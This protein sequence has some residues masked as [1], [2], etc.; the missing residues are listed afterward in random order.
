MFTVTG[1][2]R[3]VKTFHNNHWTHCTD[4][5]VWVHVPVLFWFHMRKFKNPIFCSVLK[6]EQWILVYS[7]W[8]NESKYGKLNP[9]LWNDWV[10][11]KIVSICGKRQLLSLLPLCYHKWLRSKPPR[12]PQFPAIQEFKRQVT[13]EIKFAV[14]SLFLFTLIYLVTEN[15]L[16]SV[17]S[18]DQKTDY[19][20]NWNCHWVS[21]FNVPW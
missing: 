8:I 19:C 17:Q 20:R 3:N 2:H 14:K 7:S 16:N 13:S 10:Q 1:C 5:T 11:W 4:Y 18:T 9:F 21:I 6:C 15:R 12:S